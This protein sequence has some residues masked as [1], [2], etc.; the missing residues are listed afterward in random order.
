MAAYYVLW[1]NVSLFIPFGRKDWWG[2]NR[3]RINRRNRRS[4]RKTGEVIRPGPESLECPAA[5]SVRLPSPPPDRLVTQPEGP[6]TAPCQ[7]PLQSVRLGSPG[8]WSEIRIS[9]NYWNFK[10]YVISYFVVHYI[11]RWVLLTPLLPCMTLSSHWRTLPSH[12][13]HL[14]GLPLSVDV[15]TLAG[16]DPVLVC[17]DA[18]GRPG[19]TAALSAGGGDERVLAGP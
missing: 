3:R 7:T 16:S 12:S 17:A 2:E 5:R 19:A 10:S 6:A 4:I 15:G 18:L 11:S 14:N 9:L 8:I 13:P 1:Y